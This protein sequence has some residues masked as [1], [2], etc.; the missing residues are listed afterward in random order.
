M[1]RK[2][3]AMS[4]AATLSFSKWKQNKIPC[5][6]TRVL[7][8]SCSALVFDSRTSVLTGWRALHPQRYV[9]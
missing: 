2:G 5:S 8:T 3:L 7:P 9:N 6:K 1:A 4:T